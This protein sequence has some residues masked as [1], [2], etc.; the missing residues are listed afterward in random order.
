MKKISYFGKEYTV[1]DDIKWVATSS[2]GAV[3]VFTYE[4]I[5]A[6]IGW[7]GGVPHRLDKLP[8]GTTDWKNS[9][10]KVE[11]IS[12]SVK[13]GHPHADLILKYAMIAQYD[14]KP[15]ECFECDLDKDLWCDMFDTTFHTAFNYRLKP[16]PPMVQAGQTWVSKEGVD[17]VVGAGSDK[18]T[19]YFKYHLGGLLIKNSFSFNHFIKNFKRKE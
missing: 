2:Y 9:L 12:V 15:W 8:S 17:V 5:Q 4:P 1:S 7:A 10:R 14:D 6:D 3:L 13:E 11:D 18:N 19:I 16:Q